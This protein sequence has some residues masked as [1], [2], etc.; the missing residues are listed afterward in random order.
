[1]TRIVIAVFQICFFFSFSSVS[2]TLKPPVAKKI[3]R[4][5]K[6][7]G[8]LRVDDYHWMNN[9]DSAVIEHLEAE[10]EYALKVLEPTRKLQ[11]KLYAELTAREPQ[12]FSTLP[13]ISNGY[14]YYEKT[15][16][17]KPY[18]LFFRREPGSDKEEMV[19]DFN[20]LAAGHKVLRKQNPVISPDNKFA[21]LSIDTRGNNK[22]KVLIK[23]LENDIFSKDTILNKAYNWPVW[24]GDSKGFYYVQQ[25]SVNLRPT[26]VKYHKLGTDPSKD[27]LVYFEKDSLYYLYLQP[28]GDRK[29][30]FINSYTPTSRG[31]NYVSLEG[32]PSEVMTL[33]KRKDNIQ[34]SVIDVK[35]NEIYF[36]TN[37][38]AAN[39]RIVKGT[40]NF[41]EDGPAEELIPERPEV[42]LEPYFMLVKNHLITQQR[43]NG[44]PKLNILD[45]QT[46]ENYDLNLGRE[47]GNFSVSLPND[48]MVTDSI[49]ISFNSYAVPGIDYSYNLQNRELKI[50]R[51]KKVKGFEHSGYTTIVLEV[52]VRDGTKV[53]VSMVYNKEKY[54]KDGRHPMLIETYSWYNFA[55]DPYFNSDRIS[56]LD[57][58]FIYVYP[59]ARGGAEKGP[60]WWDD[61][62]RMNRMNTFF[63]VIDCAKYLV[64]ENYTSAEKLVGTG[65]S[66]G[67]TNIGAIINLEPSLFK[68]VVA[69]VPWLDVLTDMQNTDVP[70]I[71]AEYEE[72]GNPHIREE[73]FYMAKWSP[74][75]NIKKQKYPGVFVTAGWY[76]NNVPYYHAAKW[77]SKLREFNTGSAPVLLL[78]N[79]EAGHAGSTNKFEKAK[80]TAV[81]Y[82]FL[83]NAVGTTE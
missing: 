72:E 6:E 52:P 35:G 24:S 55:N 28:S 20:I 5:F 17:G 1:M 46:R 76:D 49:Y 54:K 4:E 7:F 29:Y 64:R 27:E 81:K 22:F 69:E 75:D 79:L 19:Q 12:N 74:Y 61:G 78:T 71:A 8:N 25:D 57:R 70:G 63:D 10:N 77:V 37:D 51:E 48:I 68:A 58:G 44:V 62:R 16:E 80:L 34:Y 50:L 56:L 38:S 60:S 2:Q 36:Y 18:P 3:P 42:F 82:A 15:E 59:H 43:K 83:L 45:I 32:S 26:S 66:A 9:R 21:L 13:V 23:D 47:T 40:F 67:G 39:F 33:V 31:I 14:V 11:E 65:T 73:Y 30:L 41:A 53:P